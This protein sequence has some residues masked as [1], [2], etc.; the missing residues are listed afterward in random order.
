MPE[1][2]SLQNAREFAT[3]YGAATSEKQ[4][5]QSFWRD[6]FT[7]LVG[8][9]DLMAA[10]IEFEFPVR[11]A[12]GT[13]NFVD[14]L[15]NGVVLIEHKSAGRDLDEAERQARDYLI[16]LPAAQRP[17]AIIVSDFRRIRIVE[18][19]AGTTFEFEL[20]DL[21][22]YVSRL[23]LVIGGHAEAAAREEISADQK[24]VEL[25]ADLFVEFEK[26]GYQGHEVSVFLVRILFLNFGDDTKMW[27][28]TPRGLFGTFL[29]ATVPDGSGVG[30]RLQELFQ[31]LNTPVENRPSTLSPLLADFPYVNGGLFSET[32]PIFSFT[33][34]MR[35]VLVLTSEYDW[36]NISPAIFGSMFQTVKSKEDRR[37]LGEHFT[38]EANILK[39][40]RPLFLDEYT[41]R[42]RKAWGSV[43]SLRKLHAELAGN[44]YLDPA[45]GSGNFLV[46]AYKRLRALELKLV[47]R[48]QELE[49]KVGDVY[50]DG[51][52]GLAVTLHQ[53]HGFEINEWSSQIASVAMYLA[54]HQANLDLEEVT[55]FS[56]NRFPISDSA[57]IHHVNSLQEAWSD[58][59]PMGETTFI[60]GNPPFL[61]QTYQD[62]EQKA[63]TRRIWRDHKKTGVMDFVSNWYL[64]A[65]RE[66]EKSGGRAAFVSTNSLSQGEQVPPLWGELYG[67]GLEIDFAHRTFSWTN[68]ARGKAAVHVVIIGFS[69]RSPDKKQKKLLWSYETPKSAPTLSEVSLINPYLAEGAEVIVESRGT[70]LSPEFSPMLWGSKPTD[71][72]QLSKISSEEAQVIRNTDPLAAKY[73]RRVIGA[74]EMINGG[75][76]YCL[77]LEDAT[78]SDLNNSPVLKERVEAVRR[79]R[80]SSSAAL[81]RNNAKISHLFVQRAQPKSAYVA[82]P[83]VS[84]ETRPYVPMD[85][86]L[87]EVVANNA[88]LTVPD[89]S[90][91]VFA[92][93]MSRPFNSWNRTV[94]GRLK[95]DTRISQEVTYNNFPMRQ[96]SDVERGNLEATGQGILD[97]R[98]R[99]QDSTLA[100]MYGPNSMP[101][102]LRKAHENN[103]RAVLKIFGLRHDCSDEALIAKLFSAYDEMTRGLLESVPA[104]GKKR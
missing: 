26:A 100:D 42:L 103:D 104:K 66:I 52:L 40:I 101:L 53:F 69:R 12:Q 62:A 90:L 8:I 24:A 63:D 31:V 28:V 77:W 64:L 91:A 56:P 55:G 39:V 1:A 82:V 22:N 96:L 11:S 2:F 51:R 57:Q 27:K 46:V 9:Q 67:M 85:Y 23:E 45:C 70:P 48:I 98:A 34:K 6:F 17:P 10:G 19:L 43:S 95:S 38:S 76:R 97:A 21:P 60:M 29:D 59:C 14:V 41:E 35:E 80:A 93:L 102:E 88:L 30:G 79:F 7:Q 36:S 49:G 15:W 25:M 50:I 86:F 47:A 32:L 5:A 54:D 33:R 99:F 20:N 4:L 78:P 65:G 83:A 81:T 84:S 18:V 92:V 89:A 37:N 3:K 61:G 44:V 72:G 68:E 94:S 87:P 16:A 75:M 58:L 73:L 13:I 71:D 74:Q